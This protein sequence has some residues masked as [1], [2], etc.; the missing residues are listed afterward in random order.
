MFLIPQNFKDL[1]FKPLVEDKLIQVYAYLKHRGHNGKPAIE[2]LNTM[3]EKCSQS[4]DYKL[5]FEQYLSREE[6]SST[7]SLRSLCREVWSASDDNMD[8]QLR[9]S[10]AV[11]AIDT[12]SYYRNY[13][14]DSV[15][16]TEDSVK[17]T[18]S[19]VD[20][21]KKADRITY[22]RMPYDANTGSFSFYPRNPK[23]AVQGD[24]RDKSNWILS[25]GD[26]ELDLAQVELEY[27]AGNIQFHVL[28]PFVVI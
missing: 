2:L 11:S 25:V 7:S 5:R 1:Q 4:S 19:I 8:E 17:A 20:A 26:F 18:C 13:W 27:E 9:F 6:E 12:A 14:F 22:Q 10:N 15:Q 28:T 24:Y 21:I 3:L 16:M 23:S